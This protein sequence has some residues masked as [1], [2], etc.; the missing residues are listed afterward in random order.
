VSTRLAAA[1]VVV[2]AGLG[3]PG[4]ATDPSQGYSSQSVY[5][6]GIE[7]IAIPIFQN[8]TYFR[9]V[10]FD[11]TDAII[12]EVEARTP[13]RVAS[14]KTADSILIGQIRKVELDQISKSRFTGLGEEV[15]YGVTI[16]FQWMDLRT[17]Q[18]LVEQRSF[19]SYGLFVPS[20]PTGERKELG[21]FSAVQQLASDV[22]DELQSAW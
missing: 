9:D 5:T 6:E 19:T 11:L 2:A 3:L 10:Q 22:V 1:V 17:D 12:K 16:D 21:R 7:T 20:N 15:L 8:D 4:C 13:Y 18:T 14:Q